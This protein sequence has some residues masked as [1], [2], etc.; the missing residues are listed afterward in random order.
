MPVD[1]P[2]QAP[3][4]VGNRLKASSQPV[5]KAVPSSRVALMRRLPISL[6]D[7]ASKHRQERMV[8]AHRKKDGQPNSQKLNSVAGTSAIFTRNMVA[9][10]EF[11]PCACGEAI[12]AVIGPVAALAL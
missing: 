6:S 5:T 12:T 2:T 1:T 7:K 4:T 3:S 11:P 9:E 10:T 8:I